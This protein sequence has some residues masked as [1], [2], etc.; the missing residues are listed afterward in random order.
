MTRRE[1]TPATDERIARGE[2]VLDR[3]A[4]TDD[5]T[6]K[7]TGT[8][9]SYRVCTRLERMHRRNEITEREYKAG[10]RFLDDL[11]A[12]EAST[13]SC[14]NR[15]TGGD[16]IMAIIKNGFRMGMAAIRVRDAAVVIG[17]QLADLVFWVGWKGKPAAEWARL[18]AM[19]PR[20]GAELLGLALRKLADHYGLDSE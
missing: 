8:A 16:A 3:I 15:D 12:T 4:L 10:C 7:V 20:V 6:G 5:K 2:V 19:L 14:L 13:R 1:I 11:A 18:Q 9:E 17:P